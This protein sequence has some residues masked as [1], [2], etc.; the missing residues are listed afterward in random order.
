M[1]LDFNL[2]EIIN[3]NW[4]SEEKVVIERIIKHFKCV[5]N[6]FIDI[7]NRFNIIY[8]TSYI[9]KNIFKN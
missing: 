8:V 3:L 9:I 5:N 6:N 7:R 4:D 2:E 1:D